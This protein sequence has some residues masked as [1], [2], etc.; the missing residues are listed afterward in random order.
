MVRKRV[1]NQ[2]NTNVITKMLEIILTPKNLVPPKLVALGLS[3]FSLMVNPRL[4]RS[5]LR[6]CFVTSV[7]SIPRAGFN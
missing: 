2:K 5:I 6:D 3:L 1:L 7:L 4:L